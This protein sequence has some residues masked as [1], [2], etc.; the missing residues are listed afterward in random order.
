MR[1]YTMHKREFV[2]VFSAFFASFGLFLFIGLA[3]P[4]ITHTVTINATNLTPKLNNSQMAT[5]P[6]ILRS[7][8]LSTFSQQLW[9]I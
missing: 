6:F 2:L 5:G 7:N 4:P 3:G 9:V 8:A 1:L